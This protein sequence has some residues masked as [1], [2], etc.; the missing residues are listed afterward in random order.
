MDYYVGLY[1][2]RE[3]RLMRLE[4]WDGSDGTT[5]LAGSVTF[6]AGG[7]YYLAV[8]DHDDDEYE[9]TGGY[10]LTTTIETK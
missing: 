6:D 9:E 2:S 1:T 8:W 10:S 5:R 4:Q 7:D 3:E